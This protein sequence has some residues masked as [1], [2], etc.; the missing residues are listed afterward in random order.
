MMGDVT[1]CEGVVF[2]DKRKKQYKDPKVTLKSIHFTS[3]VAQLPK[4]VSNLCPH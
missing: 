4:T 1:P 3:D 2:M